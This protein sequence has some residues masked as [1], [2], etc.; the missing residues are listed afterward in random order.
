M[1]K[2]NRVSGIILIFFSSM[3]VAGFFALAVT[4]ATA[5]DTARQQELVDK[6][7]IT[8]DSFVADPQLEWFRSHVK[9]ARGLLIVPEML[10]GGFVLGGSGGRGVLLVRDEDTGEWGGPAFYTI[11]SVSL[12]L[13]IGAKTSEVIMMIMS[14]K[15][16]VALYRS[17]VKLGGDISIAAGPVGATAEG[18]TATNLSADYFSFAR[19]KGAFVG[20]SLEGA[21]VKTSDEWNSAYYG[22]SVRPFDI[23]VARDV[24]NPESDELIDSA[25]KAT[26]KP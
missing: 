1:K 20:V 7:R 14:Q 21:V 6:A 23:I 15:G 8:I 5:E 24:S 16:V 22:R 18:A 4:T 9:D 13:Q 10:K 12:G 17:S 11:G 3:L 25:T 19:S 2:N 26:Q